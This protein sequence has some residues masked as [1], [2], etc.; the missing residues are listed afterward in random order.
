MAFR[1]KSD[2][3]DPANE[4][5]DLESLGYFED[6]LWVSPIYFLYLINLP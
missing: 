1:Q 3:T 4:Y 6:P 5:Y 2:T